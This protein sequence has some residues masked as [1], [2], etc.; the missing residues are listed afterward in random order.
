[1]TIKFLAV[2]IGTATGLEWRGVVARHGDQGYKIFWCASALAEMAAKAAAGGAIVFSSGEP[3]TPTDLCG[4]LGIEAAWAEVHL[5][6]TLIRLGEGRVE[7]ETGTWVC[8][9]PMLSR[10]LDWQ[11]SIKALPEP[12]QPQ[13]PGRKSIFSRTLTE[14]EYKAWQRNCVLPAGVL[15][16]KACPKKSKGRCPETSGNC[17]LLSDNCLEMSGNCPEIKGG[18]FRTGG[19]EDADMIYEKKCPKTPNRKE[20]KDKKTAAGKTGQIP[21]A[22]ISPTASASQPQTL[23]PDE[24]MAAIDRLPQ[25]IRPDCLAVI[26]KH[27]HLPPEVQVSNV[28]LLAERLNG[29]K[30]EPI[31]T[32]GGWLETAL[33][34]DYAAS[35]RFAEASVAEAKKQA[36]EN[37]RQEEEHKERERLAELRRQAQLLQQLEQLPYAEQERIRLEAEGKCSQFGSLLPNLVQAACLEIVAERF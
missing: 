11:N 29:C 25:A 30:G 15:L 33:K 35:K 34:S 24:V 22:A 17:P 27:Q 12:T 18:S 16:L 31:D 6:P 28:E 20:V 19:V 4:E 13:K 37:R 14:A 26:T 10:T 9:S 21:A 32:P 3:K 7:P 36:A 2:P 8:T 23:P 1:M 5:F